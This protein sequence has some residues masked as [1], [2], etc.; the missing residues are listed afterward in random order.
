MINRD[1]MAFGAPQRYVQFG[2]GK[3]GITADEWDSKLADAVA[4]FDSSGGPTYDFCSWNCHS[5]VVHHLNSLGRA[6]WNLV[7]V[8]GLFFV[9]GR[10]STCCAVVST[11]GPMVLM[12][13]IAYALGGL[14][15]V[16]ALLRVA[17][18][19]NG[20]FVVWF[21]LAT[22]VGVRGMHGRVSSSHTPSTL[23][24]ARDV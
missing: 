5:F 17:G 10:F 22:A 13:V 9:F 4:L 15:S 3:L 24:I 16:Y 18:W 1:N 6:R 12:L 19:I 21:V 14:A 7:S 2:Y 8:C 20:V 11:F 23:S